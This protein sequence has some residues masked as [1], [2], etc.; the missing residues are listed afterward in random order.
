MK[1][2]QPSK[3]VAVIVPLS[4]N[5]E[6]SAD[7]KTSLRQLR[8]ILG[9]YDKFMIL[10]QSMN[11]DF[12]DFTMVHFDDGFFGSVP[13]HCRLLVSPRFYK[14]FK[15]YRY[16]F[17]HHLDSLVLSDQLTE[18]CDRGFDFIAPPWIRYEGAPYEGLPIEN[19]I[20]NG[21][22]SL[23]KVDSF[24]RVLRILRTPK[25]TLDYLLRITGR[26]TRIE[27]RRGEDIFWGT[28]AAGIDPAF[29]VAPLETALEYAFEC[30]P[31]LCLEMNNGKL[32]F[33]G[34]AWPRYDRAF[35]EPY[36]LPTN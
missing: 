29:R 23:R 18:W 32:P 6:L 13:N 26:R 20:G 31:R 22:F 34:H 19:H 24:L 36:I 3:Q 27:D 17:I 10:P 5:P 8:R 4:F 11:L 21:G 33:G 7:E 25:P 12:D 35:W 2:R 1:P 30:N 9:R 16:I 14:T 28:M 15:D